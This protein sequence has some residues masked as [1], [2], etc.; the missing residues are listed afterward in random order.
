V[1]NQDRNKAWGFALFGDDVRVELGGKL[2]LMGT[3]QADMFF[4]NNMPL[5]IILPKISIVV[6]Y[7]E[8]QGSIQEDMS[9]KVTYGPERTLLAD[10]PVSRKDIEGET[11]SPVSTDENTEDAERIFNIRMPINLSPFRVD[12]MGRLSVR[13][14]YSDGKILRLG[15][16]GLKQ[17]P[18]PEFQAML[19][20]R[21]NQ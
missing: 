15:S 20:I 4:P 1:T 16:L 6:M 5:P 3:Y 19:G 14:H 13:L 21:P 7:Y 8:I 2:S 9:F 12:K 10:V 11:Q 18:E 17:I